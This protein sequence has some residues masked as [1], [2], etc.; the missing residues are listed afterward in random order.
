MN[1]LSKYGIEQF[2]TLAFIRKNT[3]LQIRLVEYLV[4]NNIELVIQENNRFKLNSILN[5]STSVLKKKYNIDI[6]NLKGKG[7]EENGRNIR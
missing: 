5:C 6:K 1:L 4:D 2:I 7:E 3:N